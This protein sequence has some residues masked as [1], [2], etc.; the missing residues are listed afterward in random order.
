MLLI[1][2]KRRGANRIRFTFES[3][4]ICVGAMEKNRFHVTLSSNASLQ[5]YPNNKIWRYRTKLAKPIV[6]NEPYEVRIIE[7]QYPRVW[8]NF[9]ASDSDVVIFDY[10]SK[11]TITITLSV[12]FYD[13]IPKVVKEFY[14]KC[15][16]LPTHRP[17]NSNV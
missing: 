2:H 14:S 7:L 10:K 1:L 9:P 16:I 17:H 5:I 13:S 8:V 6:L 4:Y 3:R 15:L 11:E 12:G